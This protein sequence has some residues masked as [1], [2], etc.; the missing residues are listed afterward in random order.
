MPRVKAVGRL[1]EARE[2]LAKHSG[3]D[4]G[5]P[6]RRLEG[7]A[8]EDLSS[9]RAACVGLAEIPDVT[10]VQGQIC[11]CLRGLLDGCLVGPVQVD[12]NAHYRFTHST[13]SL[14]GP[15]FLSLDMK[16]SRLI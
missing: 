5:L 8:A 10:A 9:V 2:S 15:A 11:V 13:S 3:R 12:I 1:S 6:R 4:L 16:P 7:V 14:N